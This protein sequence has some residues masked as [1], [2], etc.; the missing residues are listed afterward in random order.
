MIIFDDFAQRVR[1]GALCKSF[2]DAGE[3]DYDLRFWAEAQV[4]EADTKGLDLLD[5]AAET[6]LREHEAINSIARRLTSTE[7]AALADVDR[8]RGRRWGSERLWSEYAVVYR[9]VSPER[10]KV[11][12]YRLEEWNHR[13]SL[14]F[15]LVGDLDKEGYVRWGQIADK[16]VWEVRDEAAE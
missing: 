14:Y 5:A 7:V 2:P 9:R 11:F 16:D 13:G 8:L 4:P 15:I 10:V 3:C 12:V 1:D 6:F